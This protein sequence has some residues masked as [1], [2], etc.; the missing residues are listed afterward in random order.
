MAIWSAIPTSLLGAGLG[1][2]DSDFAA[3]FLGAGSWSTLRNS[4][5]LNLIDEQI[6]IIDNKLYCTDHPR[7]KL[8]SYF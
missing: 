3:I 1:A 5:A 4:S 6:S 7:A 8:R 2:S